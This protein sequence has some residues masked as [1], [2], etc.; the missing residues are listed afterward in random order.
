[1][2]SP[3]SFRWKTISHLFSQLILHL[4]DNPWFMGPQWLLMCIK[5]MP[6]LFVV[7]SLAKLLLHRES[8]GQIVKEDIYT[9]SLII[10]FLTQLIPF[11]RPTAGF[12]LTI[13]YLVHI[14]MLINMKEQGMIN[15]SLYCATKHDGNLYG[16]LHSSWCLYVILAWIFMSYEDIRVKEKIFYPSSFL[17]IPCSY[18]QPIF[19][20]P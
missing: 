1:M 7:A 13:Y 16:W 11:P 17:F 4:K 10:Y 9:H 15:Y 6:F 18:H 20:L 12:F 5:C 14:I 19:S 2:L 8:T 3:F